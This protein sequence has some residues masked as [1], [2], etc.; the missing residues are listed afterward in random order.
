MLTIKSAAEI[1]KMRAAGR[2]VGD[3]LK[4]M[5]EMA[6]VGVTTAE[7]DKAADAFIRSKGA[8]PSFL[9]YNGYP[10]SICTSVNA[11][12]VHGIPGKYVLRDGDILSVDVGAELNGFHGDAARTFFV[13]NVAPEVREL[14]KVTRECFYEGMKFA[15]PGYRISDI[16]QAIQNHAESH[17]YGVVRELIGHGIGTHM[18]EPPDVPN[19]YD[20]RTGRGVRLTKGMTIAVEPMINLGGKE[21]FVYDDGWTVETRDSLP[22]AHYENTVV[23][24]DDEPQLL[25]LMG[26]DD[27]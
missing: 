8:V 24:T 5:R 6:Q 14:V 18:H 13:G 26:V 2:I 4:L 1:E 12:V 11:Q 20:H 25:T 23:I 9:H 19:Y 7:L 27:D 22:S 15:R 17:G 21:V 3:T 10:K 16:G